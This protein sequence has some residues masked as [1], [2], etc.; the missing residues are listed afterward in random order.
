MRW[1]RIG[2]AIALS[3]AVTV[4]ALTLP[5]PIPKAGLLLLNLVAVMASTLLGGALPGL[6]ATA[7]GALGTAYILPPADSLR[8][9]TRSDIVVLGIFATLA[10]VAAY[11]LDWL[12]QR[13]EPRTAA[14]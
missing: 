12:K 5:W 7:V 2:V 14:G 3:S 8:I 11:V 6:V 1:A 13:E 10:T 9:A 4:L